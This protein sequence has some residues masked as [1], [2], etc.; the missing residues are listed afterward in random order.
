M[1]HCI[2]GLRRETINR[3]A[4]AGK[5]HFGKTSSVTLTYK[6]MTLIIS[7]LS[8]GPGKSTCDKFH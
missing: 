5:L 2:D 1:V 4:S 6:S 7:P 3:Y 8:C